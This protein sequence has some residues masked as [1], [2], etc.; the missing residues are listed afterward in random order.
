PPAKA[1]RW[2][3]RAGRPADRWSGQNLP[4]GARVYYWLKDEPK[5]EVTLE[6]LD[7]AGKV[8]NTLSSK[9]REPTGSSEYVKEEK[10]ALEELALPKKAGVQRGTWNL[11]WEGA[12]V[13]PSAKLDAGYPA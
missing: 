6:V 2:G 13:I 11:A 3:Y 12:E 7:A 1:V 9:A 10:E 5:G 4:G 8:V